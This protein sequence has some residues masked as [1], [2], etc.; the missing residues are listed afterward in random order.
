[1]MLIKAAVALAA[2]VVGLFA[3]LFVLASTMSL[4]SP[5]S[6]E[7]GDAAKSALVG[8]VV[9]AI[10]AFGILSVGGCSTL[11]DACRSGDCR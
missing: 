6:V 1:M 4:N 2:L 9:L 10:C 3:F 7:R 5:N 8:L 11:V